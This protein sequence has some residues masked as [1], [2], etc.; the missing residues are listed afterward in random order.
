VPPSLLVKTN[1]VDHADWN[2]RH[3]FGAI[4]RQRFRL[5]QRHVAGL[6]FGSLLEVGYGSGIFAPELKAYCERY[7][8]I[9]THKKSAEVRSILQTLGIDAHLEEGST[10]AMP[11][12]DVTFDCVVAVSVLE[13]VD[14]Q[15]L[16]CSE[17]RRVLAP[18]GHFIVVTPGHSRWLDLGLKILTGVSAKADFGNRRES[19][20]PALR[21]VFTVERQ[22]D[23]PRFH[24][25][26]LYLYR[27]FRLVK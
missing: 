8:G 17:I 26:G 4:Q 9:D 25:P 15:K 2:Y 21:Q 18:D 10:I 1:P 13:F 6:H 12:P 27:S 19:L 16:A 3:I 22:A 7:Y 20:I 24:P 23:C 5:V 14:E 11:F